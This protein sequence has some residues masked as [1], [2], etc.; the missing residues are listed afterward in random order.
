METT[1]PNPDSIRPVVL[2][3][4]QAF[5]SSFEEVA[6][7]LGQF[8][9]KDDVFTKAFSEAAVISGDASTGGHLATQNLSNFSALFYTTDETPKDIPP[10]PYFLAGS[11]IHQ[12]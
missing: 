10:G 1:P 6:R 11:N 4:A 12:A 2:L 3:G 9:Q 8:E 5:H 7:L